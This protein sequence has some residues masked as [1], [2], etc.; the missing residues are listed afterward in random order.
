[1]VW[2]FFGGFFLVLWNTGCSASVKFVVN[3]INA[4]SSS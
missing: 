4:L 1:M 2:G 3:D